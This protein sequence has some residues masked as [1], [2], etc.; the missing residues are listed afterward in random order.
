MPACSDIFICVSILYNWSETISCSFSFLVFRFFF[1][2][3]SIF[4]SEDKLGINVSSSCFR[5]KS[6][7][8][9]SNLK[10]SFYKLFI[11]HI[12][13][14]SELFTSLCVLHGS[15]NQLQL[16][17]PI[18]HSHFWKSK[19]LSRLRITVVKFYW[20]S[21]CLVLTVKYIITSENM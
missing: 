10:Y 11:P 18:P 9:R 19:P 2:I 4:E 17:H 1:F 13:Q 15:I 21:V 3:P 12:I 16:C 20:T 5:K 8:V 14:W 7:L 6:Y